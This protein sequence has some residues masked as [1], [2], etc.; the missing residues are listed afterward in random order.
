MTD[1]NY[2][3]LNLTLEELNNNILWLPVPKKYIKE[4]FPDVR[5]KPLHECAF[6][7]WSSNEN[8]EHPWYELREFRGE[9]LAQLDNKAEYD[10]IY[11]DCEP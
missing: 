3:A 9:L 4:H 6:L 2:E 8:G 7:T 10:K 1:E 11:Q 5:M